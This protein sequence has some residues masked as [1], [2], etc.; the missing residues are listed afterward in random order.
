MVVY[1]TTNLINGKIYIGQ[2][3][4]NNPKYLGSGLLLKRAIN[5]YGIDNFVKDILEVCKSKEDLNK[6]EIFWIEK[7][8][9]VYNI[10]K[11]GN[12]GDT[13]SNHPDLE[14]IKNK[15]KGKVPYHKGKKRPNQTGDK[16]PAKRKDVREK[17]R[18]SKLDNPT[19]MFGDDNPA[20][21]LDVREKISAG[22][23]ESWKTRES[24]KCPHCD[25]E[26]INASGMYRWHFENCK[27][28]S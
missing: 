2:D 6:R 14:L 12:G 26:S 5:K 11:G 21:R 22:I 25:K 20:K 27:H 3:S 19:Q 16:N 28:K 4:H 13:L 9:P 18:Q 8:N 15:L 24:I 23:S 7:L 1:R 10:A 17:I